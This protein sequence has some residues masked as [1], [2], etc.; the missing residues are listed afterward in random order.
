[1]ARR[2]RLE[3]IAK[4]QKLHPDARKEAGMLFVKGLR[5]FTELAHHARIIMGD[6]HYPRE[7]RVAAAREMVEFW[8]ITRRGT[9]IIGEI[10][11]SGNWPEIAEEAGKLLVDYL[12]AR[13]NQ[14]DVR[15]IAA[16]SG[17]PRSV[18]RY[19]FGRIGEGQESDTLTEMPAVRVGNYGEGMRRLGVP[20]S[21]E[22]I[23][24]RKATL[25]GPVK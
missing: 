15:R 17:T 23:T 25:R 6:G 21:P 8:K 3:S 1:M 13:G 11:T 7:V 24:G 18:S 19:A 16:A 9:G 22:H 10:V 5:G 14:G 2:E 20:P 12:I 4:D